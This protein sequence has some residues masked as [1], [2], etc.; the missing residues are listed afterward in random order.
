MSGLRQKAFATNG[1]AKTQLYDGR[2][3]ENEQDS[4]LVQ[5]AKGLWRKFQFNEWTFTLLLFL[6]SSSIVLG[7]IFLN[8]GE[9]SIRQ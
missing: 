2:V 8:I 7:K 9:R 4:V 1:Q 3:A 5:A 6:F